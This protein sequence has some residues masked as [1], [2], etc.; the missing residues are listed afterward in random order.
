MDVTDYDEEHYF[1]E[2]TRKGGSA[3]SQGSHEFLSSSTF[4]S[5]SQTGIAFS[6]GFLYLPVEGQAP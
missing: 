3:N 1:L 5:Q 6:T 4:S 2:A